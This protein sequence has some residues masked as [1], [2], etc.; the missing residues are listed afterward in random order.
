MTSMMI[1]VKEVT[2]LMILTNVKIMM[3]M[4]IIR[5]NEMNNNSNN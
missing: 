3:Q 5:Y 1:R 4:R 2:V